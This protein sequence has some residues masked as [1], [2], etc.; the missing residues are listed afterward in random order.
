MLDE[1]ERGIPSAV[2]DL[3]ASPQ[4]TDIEIRERMS[5]NIC[6]CS[7]YPNIVAAILEAKGRGVMRAFTY[8]RPD[9]IGAAVANAVYNAC[10]ARVRDYPITLDKVLPELV[11]GAG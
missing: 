11:R 7:A 5:G 8:E 2:G 3:A 1:I 9:T 4:A 6:R 10:G